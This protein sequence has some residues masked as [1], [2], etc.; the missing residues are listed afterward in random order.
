MVDRMDGRDPW[1]GSPELGTEPD[2]PF[3]EVM[4]LVECA[5]TDGGRKDRLTTKAV[6]TPN[7]AETRDATLAQIIARHGEALWRRGR[8]EAALQEANR[9]RALDP[10]CPNHASLA[11]QCLLDLERPDQ[12]LKLLN[13]VLLFFEAGPSRE[14]IITLEHEALR[15]SVARLLL[16]RAHARFDLDLHSE[17]FDDIYRVLALMPNMAEAYHLQAL[18]H[19]RRRE[20]SDALENLS[21]ALAFEP[22]NP[23]FLMNLARVHKEMDDAYQTIR[24][25]NQA[26]EHR[27][28]R[29][30]LFDLR[31]WAHARLGHLNAAESDFSSAVTCNPR[32]PGFLVNR[33]NNRDNMGHREAAL[34]DCD[35]ALALD[36]GCWA[37]Y[38][39]RGYLHYLLG[40]FEKALCDFSTAVELEP[41]DTRNLFNKGIVS[42]TLEQYGAAIEV[43][44][45]LLQRDVDR[46]EALHQRAL[47]HRGQG[48]LS[49][50]V[51]DLS[52]AIELEPGNGSYLFRRAELFF[53]MENWAGTLADCD[54]ALVYHPDMAEA[55]NLRGMVRKMS[56]DHLGALMDFDRAI[57]LDY[58]EFF[59]FFNKAATHAAME[60]WELAVDA[61]AK[62]LAR[63]PRAHTA[64]NN[65]GLAYLHLGLLDDALYDFNAAIDLDPNGTYYFSNRANVL[66]ELGQC[67]QAVQDC[68]RALALDEGN[69][70]AYFIRAL[71]ER[72]FH[73][74]N[75]ALADLDRAIAL[76]DGRAHFFHTRALIYGHQDRLAEAVKDQ[77]RA[78]ELEPCDVA[79]HYNLGCWYA[80]LGDVAGVMDALDR[81]IELDRKGEYTAQIRNDPDFDGVRG[82]PEFRAM[83]ASLETI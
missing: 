56:G 14:E 38:G 29:G 32:K 20:W 41:D 80:R 74:E 24:V 40:H 3:R 5:E 15:D 66:H 62:A 53:E 7:D 2:G 45:D 64:Y 55:H 69:A 57:A 75:R 70:T 26:L 48:A 58:R 22:G 65:R 1:N 12:A 37:A 19:R 9:A 44:D 49:L 18:F 79:S 76:D 81:V 31:G 83:L 73:R 21:L 43:F 28:F 82:E 8:P 63:D 39:L 27:T 11:A 67:D 36:P 13:Q 77:L 71:I 72:D 46:A 34:E 33:A 10:L 68:L 59:H 4:A 50:A 30:E 47:C 6:A 52:E 51:S 54:R 35:R 16:L 17:A 25:C 61:Y 42:R 78:I 23:L 60:Q